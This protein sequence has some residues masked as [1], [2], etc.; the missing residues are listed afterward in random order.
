M[1]VISTAKVHTV[2]VCTLHLWQDF[3]SQEVYRHLACKLYQRK[4]GT[5]NQL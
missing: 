5:Q 1:A 2:V 3:S 4:Y